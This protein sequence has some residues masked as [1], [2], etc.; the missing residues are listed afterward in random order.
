MRKRDMLSR[1]AHPDGSVRAKIKRAGE[2]L[3]Q[4]KSETDA[5]AETRKYSFRAEIERQPDRWDAFTIFAVA[6]EPEIDPPLHIGTVMGDVAH[7][8]RS[9]LDHLICGLTG[10]QCDGTQFPIC[11]TKKGWGI[12]IKKGRLA[13]V[14][15]RYW[16]TIERAQPYHGRI[17]GRALK[18]IREW[19]NADKHRTLNPMTAASPLRA[20]VF[21]PPDAILELDIGPLGWVEMKDGAEMMRFRVRLRPGVPNVNVNLDQSFT[22]AFGERYPIALQDVIRVRTIVSRLA[23]RI[24]RLAP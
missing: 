4:L 19:S 11:D 3:R 8:L 16:A 2:H 1:M 5:W 22:I 24:E 12:E 15:T 13:G 7:N 18:A 14:D 6:D 10:G 23:R 20:P 17:T 21:T 9:A